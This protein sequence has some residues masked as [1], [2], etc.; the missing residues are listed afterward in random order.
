MQS[1]Q[2]T[3]SLLSSVVL[4]STALLR[5]TWH[6]SYPFIR[7]QRPFFSAEYFFGGHRRKPPTPTSMLLQTCQHPFVHDARLGIRAVQLNLAP[8]TV[9]PSE[10]G[11]QETNNLSAIHRSASPANDEA[12]A[13]TTTCK[14]AMV[15][16]LAD[17]EQTPLGS[18]LRSSL[19]GDNL[20]YLLESLAPATVDLRMPEFHLD[21]TFEMV[22]QLRCLGMVD[23][24][25]QQRAD[26]RPMLM[27][28]NGNGTSKET[29]AHHQQ[30]PNTVPA[31]T[32][33]LQRVI[34]EVDLAGDGTGGSQ[35]WAGG[36]HPS[37][38]FLGHRGGPSSLLDPMVIHRFY[39]DRPFL[40]AL[41]TTDTPR[42]E[43]LFMGAIN[44]PT[45]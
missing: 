22:D 1:S 45:V 9:A 43:V 24:F 13:A 29:S 32:A 30:K 3:S 42:K 31:V 21:F 16:F 38:S 39:A 26:L 34:V 40:F 15:L 10:D 19:S 4:I 2:T 14:V 35:P 5:A 44:D 18:L 37:K 17:S 33:V 23:V 6:P 41:V 7:R 11:E 12:A 27:A 36:G 8:I 25:S 28:S 20:D